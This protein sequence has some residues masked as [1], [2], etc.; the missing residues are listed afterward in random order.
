ML[1]RL[2]RAANRSE[3]TLNHLYY[4]LNGYPMSKFDAVMSSGELEEEPSAESFQCLVGLIKQQENHTETVCRMLSFITP[5]VLSVV[6]ASLVFCMSFISHP[7]AIVAGAIIALIGLLVA[8][9]KKIRIDVSIFIANHTINKITK[10]RRRVSRKLSDQLACRR[11][12]IAQFHGEHDRYTD[13]L[14]QHEVAVSDCIR[15][16]SEL[17]ASLKR[18][19]N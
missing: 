8:F 3:G 18:R 5:I 17:I 4:K 12:L 9:D 13:L 16:N 14:K 2:K 10:V 15:I 1:K 7:G 6:M 11:K 19:M